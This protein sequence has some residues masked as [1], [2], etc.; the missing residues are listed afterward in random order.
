MKANGKRVFW[1]L[2][3]DLLGE[4]GEPLLTETQQWWMR[5]QGGKFILD[6]VWTGTAKVDVTVA[7]HEYGGLF[8]RMPWRP[9]TVGSATNAAR[10]TNAAAEG[11]RAPWLDVGME[12]EGREDQAHIAILDHHENK[13]FPQQCCLTC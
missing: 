2:S 4:K 6:L 9:G 7:K 11:Q 12:I 10:Q 13:G 3:Y 8:L 5:E 1:Q